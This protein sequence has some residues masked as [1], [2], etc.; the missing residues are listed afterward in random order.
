M[1]TIKFSKCPVGKHQGE[2]WEKI[3]HRTKGQR[4]TT[5]RAYDWKHH[6]H[7]LNS[8]CQDFQVMEEGVKKGTAKLAFVDVL[9]C[10]GIPLLEIQAD[11]FADMTREDWNALMEKF[12]G[13]HTGLY[14]TRLEFEW[15]EVK[16]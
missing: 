5:Y 8:I 2:S 6:S 16:E 15:I 13:F 12:Y 10:D 7:Y 11:T 3:Q 14:M 9:E 4:F 1:K